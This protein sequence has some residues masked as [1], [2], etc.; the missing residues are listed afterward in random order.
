MQPQPTTILCLASYF[1][2]A[3]FLTAAKAAGARVL[4]LTRE[5]NAAEPWPREHIDEVFLMPDLR[6]RPDIFHAIS[7]LTRANAIDAIVPLDDYDVETAAALREHLRLPGLGETGARY[8]RDKL[9]MRT[10]A[11]AAG[12][13]VPRFSPVFSYNRLR[14]YMARVSPPWVLKP[15]SEAGAMGIRK[16]NDSE[17][18]WR[19]LDELG[20]EQSFFHL[21]Q[22]IPGDIYHVDSLVYDRRVLF[23]QPHKYARP[24]MTV[25]HDGGVFVSRTLA[26]GEEARAIL[27]LNARLLAAFDLER[28]A[29]HAEFIRGQD[30]QYY[31][32]EVAARVGGANIEQLVEAASG[33]NLWSEWARMEIAFAQGQPYNVAPTRHD[34]AG[35]LVCL[36]RQEWPNLSAYGDP[37]VVYRVDKKHHAGLVVASPD[38]GRV[39]ALLN[40][41]TNRFAGDFLAVLPPLEKAPT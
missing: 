22:F 5:K 7:Y 19:R 37:E 24:P 16:L 8:F 6:R 26:D 20:D 41:Y 11:S 32:L 23:A 12:I 25:A 34:Y 3:T 10:Q 39:E 38:P 13:P 27:D 29:T 30:G 18:V 21:E 1:K 31:F 17:A 15:R 2:G 4:L 9:A 35:I 28:G 33:L 40:E 36:A 14:D